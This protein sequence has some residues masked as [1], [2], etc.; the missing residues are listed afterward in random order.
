MSKIKIKP[1]HD[2]VIVEPS[3]IESKTKA[4]IIIP[5][6]AKEKPVKGKVIAVGSGS[7]EEPMTVKVNDIVLYGKHAGSSIEIEG[8][9][10][11][12]MKESEILVI[13]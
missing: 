9:S 7:K 13:L 5:D 12:I 11:L 3:T 4:G 1:L 8:K 6:T 10:Y 2:R